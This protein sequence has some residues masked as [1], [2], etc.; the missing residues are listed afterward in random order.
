VML[1][2]QTQQGGPCKV[3]LCEKKRYRPVR[4]ES[5]ARNPLS[6]R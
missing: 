2:Q 6:S 5:S 4:Q 1:E 3:P